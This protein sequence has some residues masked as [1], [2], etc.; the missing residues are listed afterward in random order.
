MSKLPDANPTLTAY[1]VRQQRQMVRQANS[2][3]FNRSGASVAE[4]VVTVDGELDVTGAMVVGGTLSLPNGIINNDALT[5]PTKPDAVYFYSSNFA[6]NTT[7]TALASRTITVPAGFTSAVVSLT[8]RVYANNP[9]TT[10]GINGTGGDYLYGKAT[11]D[12]ADCFSLPVVVLGSGSSGVS[13]SSFS[14][15]K[16]GLTPGSTFVVSVVGNTYLLSWT[17]NV[18]NIAEVSGIITWYR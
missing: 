1:L 3:S 14:V 15:V 8:A 4:G 13:V 7:S 18:V 9:N 17:A 12:G 2:S 5:S 11:I 10:G 16:T 6:L